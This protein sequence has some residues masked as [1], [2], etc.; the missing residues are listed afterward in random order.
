M[1]TP[2]KLTKRQ[3]ELL[4]ELNGISKVENL[5][6]KNSLFSKMKDIFG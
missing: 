5:P 4:E 3:R 2:A 6:Q 1:Q